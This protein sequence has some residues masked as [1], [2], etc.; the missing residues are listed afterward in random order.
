MNANKNKFLY[1]C[2][3]LAFCCFLTSCGESSGQHFRDFTQEMTAKYPVGSEEKI[4]VRNLKLRGY[5]YQAQKGKIDG[6]EGWQKLTKHK[7]TSFT[8]GN[9]YQVIWH[10]DG[11]GK[12]EKIYAGGSSACL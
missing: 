3:A 8:C 12:I 11:N 2:I 9:E 5:K 4:L 6:I 10:A 7:V 1:R